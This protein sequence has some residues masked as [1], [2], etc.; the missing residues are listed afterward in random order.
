MSEIE[1]I[2]FWV[3]FAVLP[4]LFFLLLSS[5]FASDESLQL[6]QKELNCTPMGFLINPNDWRK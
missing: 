4:L 5:C 1:K 6:Q 2:P 3:A